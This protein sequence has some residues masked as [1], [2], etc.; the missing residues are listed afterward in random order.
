MIAFVQ[1]PRCTNDA[2]AFLG[3]QSCDLLANSPA[4]AGNNGDT[5]VQLAHAASSKFLVM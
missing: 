2:R 3:E 5:A 4:G 1:C